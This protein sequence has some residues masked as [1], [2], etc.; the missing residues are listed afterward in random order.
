MAWDLITMTTSE[1]MD[2][3]TYSLTEAARLL[4]VPTSTMRFW[5]E[6]ARR[7]EQ[8]YPPV[9]RPEATGSSTLT[10]GEFVEAAY[11]REYRE[12]IPVQGL[13]PLIEALREEFGR[14]P[15]ATAHPMTTDKQLVRNLQD[16]LGLPEELW[17]VVGVGQ[18]VLGSSAET[19][20][21][22]V[23]F[24]PETS[25][26]MRYRV[27]DAETPVVVD[28]RVAFGVPT[29]K[30]TRAE[31]IAELVLAGEPISAVVQIYAGYG[32]NESDVAT[33]VRF[34]REYLSAAA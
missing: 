23:E 5:L 28:P 8:V 30:N 26:A 27:M 11:L 9:L 29:I 31:S 12:D 33:A 19:Y 34:D 24:D 21:K 18:L 22:K 1:Y 14:Y 16:Q 17:M 15:L 25:L 10:W 6:G 13:R 32:I 20:F 4:R 2:R 3:P 7:G